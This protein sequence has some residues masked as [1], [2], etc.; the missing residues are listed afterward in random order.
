[1][2]KDASIYDK[3]FEEMSSEE[4]NNLPADYPCMIVGP[5]RHCLCIWH[6]P[7]FAT[8]IP[9]FGADVTGMTW[10]FKKEPNTW[11]LTYRWRY[12]IDDTGDPHAKDRKVWYYGAWGDPKK[13]LDM[14]QAMAK[15]L[16]TFAQLS[17]S[18]ADLVM[19]NGDMDTLEAMIK[20][21]LMPKWFHA[22][23]EAKA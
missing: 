15:F 5:N 18:A 16:Q 8:S 20:K 19:V 9:P 3:S 1:M 6:I 11:R 4:R 12:Y 10:R 13:K 21:G 7:F 23:K 17:G 2:A 14:A 22:P